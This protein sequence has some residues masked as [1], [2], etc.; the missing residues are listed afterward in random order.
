MNKSH[1]GK[2]VLLH[3]DDFLLSKKS[4]VLVYTLSPAFLTQVF[5]VV[6]TPSM[7]LNFLRYQETSRALF[8]TDTHH[9]FSVKRQ[10]QDP[11]TPLI[12]SKKLTRSTWRNMQV[13]RIHNFITVFPLSKTIFSPK[14]NLV[15]NSA[16]F[17]CQAFLNICSSCL[18]NGNSITEFQKP[19]VQHSWI[20]D[21]K[22]DHYIITE[23]LRN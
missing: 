12:L 4:H 2:H 11:P 14:M 5:Y 15:C 10:T 8:L 17:N 3:K 1:K 13:K 21:H 9:C 22:L 20:L 18:W 6:G 7:F 16:K 23:V 19:K